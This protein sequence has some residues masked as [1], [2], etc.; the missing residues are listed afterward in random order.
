MP[1][2]NEQLAA[3]RQASHL[4]LDECCSFLAD[5]CSIDTTNPP[6]INYRPCASFIADHLKSLNY[7]TKLLPVDMGDLDALAPHAEGH[8]RVNVIGQRRSEA[9][10]PQMVTVDGVTREKTL[11][12]NGHFDIVPVGDPETWNYPPLGGRIVEID[13]KK[14]MVARGVSDMKGGIAAGIWAAEAIKRAGLKL[15]GTVEHSGVVDEESTGVRNAGAGWLVEQGI[16]SSKTADAV[17]ITEPLNVENVCLGHRG[18]LWGEIRFKGVASHGATPQ[19]GVNALVHASTFVVRANERII[20][21][22]QG[23]RDERVIPAE[24]RNASLTFTVLQAGANTN[25]V[26]DLA[27]L[28]F[29]RRL[30]PGEKLDEARGQIHSVL[31]DCEAELGGS[32][33]FRYEY[34]ETYSTEPV[35]VDETQEVCTAWADAVK[36]VICQQAGIVC[37]PGSDDQRFFVRGGIPQTIVYGP[38]NIKQLAG[39]LS[40][41]QW[42]V[43]YAEAQALA[44]RA[45]KLELAGSYDASFKAYLTAA[46]TY[47]LLIRHTSDAETA[48]RLRGVSAKLVER[49]ER[50]KLARKGEV[51]VVREDRLSVEAQDR[52]LE[53]GSSVNGLRLPRWRTHDEQGITSVAAAPEQPALSSAQSARQCT[54]IRAPEVFQNAHMYDRTARGCDIVQDNVS[55]CSLIAALIVAAEHHAHIGSRLGI[56]CLFPQDSDGLP[57]LSPTGQYTAKMLLNGT[58]R[59]VRYD[60]HHLVV[61]VANRHLPDLYDSPPPWC[62]R[63]PSYSAFLAAIDD[64]LPVSAASDPMCAASRS[65]SQLWPSLVEKA[66][67]R[68]MGGYEFVGS[69]SANDLYALSGW[70]PESVSLRSGLR[71]E[72]T[73][74]RI[75]KGYNLGKC[76]LTLG[77]GKAPDEVLSQAGL[78]PSHNYAVV[79]L[80]EQQGRREVV[81]INPWRTTSTLE[82]DR[83]ISGLRQALTDEEDAPGALVVDWESIAT[84]FASIHLNW[85]PAVFDHFATVHVSTPASTATSSKHR[86]AAQLRLR[87]DQEP[88]P[89][90]QVWL[91]VARH[92]ASPLQKGEFLGLSVLSSGQGDAAD[93]TSRLKLDDASSMTDNLFFLYRFSPMPSVS[94]Y[95]MIISHEG[96]Y[97]TFS[98]SLSA[99]SNTPLHLEDEPAPLT[100]SASIQGAWTGPSAGG[101]HTCHTF[102]NNPQ[103]CVRL[104]VPP[105]TS[106]EAAVAARLKGELSVTSETGKDSPI[107][108]KL[109]MA[110][111]KRVGDFNDRDVLAGSSTYNY[112]RDALRKTG[113]SP[114]FY[115]LLVSSFTPYHLDQFTLSLKSSLPISVTPIPAEGAGMYARTVRGQWSEGLDGGREERE[116]NPKFRVRLKGGKATNVKI[117]LQLPSGPLPSA[118]FLYT[119]TAAAEPDQLVASTLPYADPVCG[120]VIESVRLEPREEGYVV[121]PATYTGGVHVPFQILLYADTPVSF[122]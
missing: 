79:G 111:G 106:P 25:S 6:G 50:I 51:T 90:S 92:S 44:T 23:R 68:L 31:K 72:Q 102:L 69:N 58:W 114:G 77:T 8:E 85:D 98:F 122:E 37:S 46:Q 14:V 80:R 116:R 104:T 27:V 82:S 108:I 75:S 48:T 119:S 32:E 121:V 53:Q 40:Q 43:K 109:I 2:T 103:Y 21:L 83:W 28:R 74:T 13:G 100:Y 52:V 42:A 76:V 9:R 54:W 33:I 18:A 91:F 63:F 29:D 117:R 20:P 1:L 71:S 59:R 84:H 22:L 86:H 107:N 36:T 105:G 110:D 113:L 15:R 65:R 16:V 88:L 78:V 34:H 94:T 3:I 57:T 64:K 26:P 30:V 41:A 24:A 61:I 115:T 35:W 10:E 19:R 12:Y 93:N 97:P 4:V 7:D 120:V 49:A 87:L 39:S 66:Y 99:Y 112:G 95:D 17:V 47:L 96:A 81:L 55:D 11:H 5:F 101:N 60:P 56:S 118:L 62:C 45:T 38:G 73:W 89:S 67:L 70:L